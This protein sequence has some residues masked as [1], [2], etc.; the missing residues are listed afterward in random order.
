MECKARQYPAYLFH[1][2]K[3]SFLSI[4]GHSLVLPGCAYKAGGSVKKSFIL[5]VS[6]LGIYMITVLKY[7]S[8]IGGFRTIC[9]EG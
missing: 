8:E 5:S 2:Q 3:M 1:W 6:T 9:L 7:I 4:R